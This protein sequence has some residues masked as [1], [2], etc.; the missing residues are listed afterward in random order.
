MISPFDLPQGILLLVTDQLASPADFVLHRSL[1]E[2]LKNAKPNAK[3][4][5]AIVLSVSEHLA[6]WKATAA[7]SNVNLEQKT[8]SGSFVFIDVLERVP[9]PDNAL[10]GDPV[11]RPILDAV[12]SVLD[13]SEDTLVIVDDLAVLEWIGFALLDITRFCRALHA[14]CRKARATLLIRQHVMTPP[15]AEPL[16]DDLFR[17]LFQMS[18][19]H[20]EILPLS[21][22]RSGAVS[23]QVALHLG[24]G[25]PHEVKLLPRSSALQYKLTDGGAVFFERGTEAGIL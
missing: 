14:T 24:P 20:M 19:Y 18:S 11:L 15:T 23:G 1:I 13:E 9:P 5:K 6:R 2:H 4:R 12:V 25:M 10:P 22:G 17:H 16:L 7:K 3:K 8:A 21:S